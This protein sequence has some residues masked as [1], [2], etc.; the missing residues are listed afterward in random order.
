MA[1]FLASAGSQAQRE[2]RVGQLRHSVTNGSEILRRIW[3]EPAE[4]AE[5]ENAIWRDR[6]F[7][8]HLLYKRPL[9]VT[10]RGF[11]APYVG[12]VRLAFLACTKRACFRRAIAQVGCGE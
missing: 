9:S 8:L 10:E 4:P 12:V 2:R 11:L 3:I 1:K 7:E 5:V 6:Q